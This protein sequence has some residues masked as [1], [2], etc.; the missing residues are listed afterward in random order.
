M[1]EEHHLENLLITDQNSY[2]ID[3]NMIICDA[4][5]YLKGNKKYKNAFHGEYMIQYSWA[6][7]ELYRFE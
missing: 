7:S 5:E 6:E 1:L 2:A 4:Y 3:T